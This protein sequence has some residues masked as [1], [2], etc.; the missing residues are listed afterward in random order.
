[1]QKVKC[2]AVVLAAGRGSR[3]K[4]DREKQFLMIG[5]YPLI[6]YAL[7]CFERSSLI[8]EIVLVASE[9]NREQLQKEIVEKYGFQKVKNIVIGGAERYDSSYAGLLGCDHPDVVFIHD[10]ARP[11]IDGAMLERQLQA[12]H[13]YG[14]AVLAMPTKDTIKIVDENGQVKST[15]DRRNVWI[16]Q[17]PQAFR[18][19]LIRK[20]HEQL[21]VENR[22][23]TITD[24]AMVAEATGICPVKVVEG[25]YNNIKVTTPEDLSL[26]ENILRRRNSRK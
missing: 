19:D 11:F 1:M 13:Q 2:S 4:S 12:V 10:S 25:S 23:E 17:T 8:D 21:R 3:M 18:Y 20:A 24:D 5:E 26:A 9:G 15:P 7:D 22:M 14:G 6:Y 16:V